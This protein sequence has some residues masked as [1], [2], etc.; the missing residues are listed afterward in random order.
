MGLKPAYRI[1]ANGND[2][3]EILSS[4]SARIVIADKT[5]V[6]SDALTITVADHIP[7]QR[8]Q[9]PK[10]GAELEAWIGYDDSAVKFGLFVVDEIELSGPPDKIVI[11]AHAAPHTLSKQG[12]KS[13]QTQ[14]TRSWEIGTTLGAMVE[15]IAG[16]HGLEPKI[17]G[18][19]AGILLPHIDQVDES[20]VN[21]LTRIGKDFGAMVKPADGKLVVVKRG[22]GETASGG[23]LPTVELAREQIT[24][25]STKEVERPTSGTVIATWY[26]PKTAKL[27]EEK[28]GE[29]EPITRLKNEYPDQQQAKEAAKA[30]LRK[31]QR[32][33]QTISIKMPGRND[34]IAEG[35]VVL[36]GIRD[37]VN[38]EWS[39]TEVTHEI[40]NAGYSCSWKGEIPFA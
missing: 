29:G 19:L 32:G 27:N 36:S 24:S 25:W 30:E 39:V 26:D 31:R 2:I 12:K 6:N 9:T 14:K 3:T 23:K 33:G 4:R 5:G 28:A 40:S 17:A 11:R 16:E 18:D 13:L 15:T 8:I 20:D 7:V 22:E 10:T 38:G 1:V 35:R 37:G 34:I 21:L